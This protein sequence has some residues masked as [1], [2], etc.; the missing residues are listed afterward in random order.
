MA[1]QEK[2]QDNCVECAVADE[3]AQTEQHYVVVPSKPQDED[4]VNPSTFTP[5]DLSVGPAVTIEYCDR[6]SS[7]P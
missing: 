3:A 1:E 4:I 7:T 6:V 2:S 5:P